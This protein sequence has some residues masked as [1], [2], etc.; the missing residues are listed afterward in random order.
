M[1]DELVVRR[2]V[3]LDQRVS[4]EQVPGQRRVDAPVAH[5]PGGHDGQAV[6]R[7]PFGRH[8]RAPLGRP[9]RLAVGPLD[10]VGADALDPLRLDP[11]HRARPEA[12]G[13]D[14][15]RRHDPARRL[16][17]QRRAGR[18][19]EPG[20]VGAEELDEAAATGP[21]VLPVSRRGLLRSHPDLRQE[22]GQQRQVDGIGV[23]VVPRAGPDAEVAGD[24]AHLAVDV[25]PLADPKVVEELASAHACRNWFDD[26]SRCCLAQVRPE[27]EVR[28]EVG[29][30]GRRSGG[31]ARRPPAACPSAA[32]AGPGWTGRRR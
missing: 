21:R 11:C 28:Q 20:V 13:L 16:L 6:E 10:E 29:V 15:L 23:D 7:D 27:V 31:G 9:V 18:D 24:L 22:P 5:L 19:G 4:D 17:R 3:V 26:S 14:E 32:P 2:P 25:L 12:S 1:A 30:A 8:H